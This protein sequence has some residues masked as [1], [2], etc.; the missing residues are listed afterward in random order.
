MGRIFFCLNFKVDF[1]RDSWKAFFIGLII[2][3]FVFLVLFNYSLRSG[4]FGFSNDYFFHFNKFLGGCY[5]DVY[6]KKE[7]VNYPDFY[8]FVFSLILPHDEFSF[9]LGNLWLI[10]LLIPMLMGYYSKS[11]FSPLIYFS[12]MTPFYFAFAST[13]AQAFMVLEFVAFF[14]FTSFEARLV[15]AALALFTHRA[16]FYIF[17]PLWLYIWF[18]NKPF[19]ELKHI[20]FFYDFYTWDKVFWNFLILTPFIN[21]IFLFRLAM[22]Q[23]LVVFAYFAGAF[24]VAEF[25]ATLYI[26]ILLALWLP[27]VIQG[28]SKEF[29]KCLIGVYLLSICLQFVFF[30]N[31]LAYRH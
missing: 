6:T 9:V 8:H 19:P 1:M 5:D 26:P 28:Y 21:F 12:S 4:H 10:F 22:P 11:I 18:R 2:F 27:S 3:L 17:V 16:S 30:L 14:V 23:I 7:C 24:F 20:L 31:E 15:I 25:R 29:Q 13:F